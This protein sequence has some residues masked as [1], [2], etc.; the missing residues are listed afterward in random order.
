MRAILEHEAEIDPTLDADGVVQTGLGPVKDTKRYTG[1]RVQWSG[2]FAGGWDVSL[3]GTVD[4]SNYVVIVANVVAAAI[5]EVP[6]FW[7]HMRLNVHTVGDAGEMTAT[8][9]GWTVGDHE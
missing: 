1:T 4:G 7:R 3:E 8:L 9:G 5:T 2:T 6:A